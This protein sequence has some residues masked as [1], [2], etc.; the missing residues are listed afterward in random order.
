MG[1]GMLSGP[2]LA[3]YLHDVFDAYPPIFVLI[4]VFTLFTAVLLLLSQNLQSVEEETRSGTVT[5]CI[6]DESP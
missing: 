5:P 6:N 3:G 2:P 1:L 4:A